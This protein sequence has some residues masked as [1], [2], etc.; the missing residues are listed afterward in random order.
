MDKIP[1][2]KTPHVGLIVRIRSD[3]YGA[4]NVGAWL[5]CLEW[6]NDDVLS[7]VENRD[8]R[9]SLRVVMISSESISRSELKCADSI[10]LGRH[11]TRRLC[12]SHR[13]LEMNGVG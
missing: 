1:D 11:V 3:T 5:V 6:E 12:G 7:P 2:C 13:F 4:G 8:T 9:S 10:K